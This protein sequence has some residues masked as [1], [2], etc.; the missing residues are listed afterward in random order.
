M[1][2][3]LNVLH[4]HFH[5]VH[6]NSISKVSADMQSVD[7]VCILEQRLAPPVSGASRTQIISTSAMVC[8]SMKKTNNFPNVE[9]DTRM[10][11][12]SIVVVSPLIPT[13]EDIDVAVNLLP[14]GKLKLFQLLISNFPME[15]G[16]ALQSA[17][18]S[19]ERLSKQSFLEL[20]RN[21]SAVHNDNAC[22]LGGRGGGGGSASAQLFVATGIV[23]LFP[24]VKIHLSNWYTTV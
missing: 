21:H 19:A 1:S 4:K 14:V 6:A 5:D 20:I 8:F 2:A 16:Q 12:K 10:E 11:P 13:G 3:F 23:S 18:T 9:M 7:G 22:L 15:G 17:C 24:G